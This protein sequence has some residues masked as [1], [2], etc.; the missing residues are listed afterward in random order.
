MPIPRMTPED[1]RLEND[2]KL[3][4]MLTRVSCNKRWIVSLFL[5]CVFVI[6]C[7]AKDN[8][9]PIYPKGEIKS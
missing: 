4:L 5:W 2:Y 3:R 1:I 8:G 9:R 7:M 6:G